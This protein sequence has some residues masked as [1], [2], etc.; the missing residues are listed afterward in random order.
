MLL[1]RQLTM[2]LVCTVSLFSAAQAQIIVKLGTIAPEQSV[3]H[4]ALLRIRQDWRDISNGQVELRIYAGGVLGGEDEMIRKMQRRGLDALAISGS[5]LPQIDNI[6]SCLEIPL[7]FESYEQLDR[8]R[9]QVA[10][11]LEAALEGRGYKVLGWLEAGWVHF[12]AK[13]PVREPEDLRSQRLWISTGEPESE[14][15]FNQIGF[16]VVA[17]PVTDMLTGLQTGL[18]DAIDVPPLF[19]LVDRSY[20]EA[21]YMTDLRFAPLNSAMLM[22]SSVWEKLPQEYHA[23]FIDSVHDA[24]LRL[25]SEIQTAEREAIQEMVARGLTL[26]EVDDAAFGEWKSLVESVYPEL[27]CNREHLELFERVLRLQREDAA[28]GPR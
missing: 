6:V 7:L 24:I 20:R 13:S 22:N 25:R 3:W 21:P 23:R 16:R 28:R 12:F 1:L 27:A 10:P 8:V 18:I 26:V 5:A 15:L 17:L 14:R 11:E 2:G 4:D 19:A 9:A